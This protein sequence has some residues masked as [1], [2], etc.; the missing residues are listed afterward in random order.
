[1]EGDRDSDRRW[2]GCV[3]P[4]EEAEPQAAREKEKRKKWRRE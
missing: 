3:L 1:V 2:A 4:V